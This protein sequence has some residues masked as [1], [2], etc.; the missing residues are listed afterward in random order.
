MDNFKIGDAVGF[1]EG[2]EKYGKLVAIRR[3]P[4]GGRIFVI[5]CYDS[6]TGETYRTEQAERDCWSEE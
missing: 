1:K 2:Y 5:E 4:F 3:N 6:N